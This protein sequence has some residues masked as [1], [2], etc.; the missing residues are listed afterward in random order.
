MSSVSTSALT[1]GLL[2]SS[3]NS[4]VSTSI[5]T[6]GIAADPSPTVP[7]LNPIEE[8]PDPADVNMI[9]MGM[10]DV[11]AT[12]AAAPIVRV[13]PP[14]PIVR[15]SPPA[16]AV[17]DP[18][19]LT[20][21]L[22]PI[23]F[24]STPSSLTRTQLPGDITLFT[25]SDIRLMIEVADPL[26]PTRWAKQLIEASTLTISV[27]RVK[28]P[29][30]A[31]GYIGAKGYSRGGRT[32]AGTMVLTE[33]GKDALFEFLAAF[34][35]RD[36]SKDSNIV[37]VDQIP[38][39]NITMLLTNEAGFASTRRLLGVDMITD[40][41]V[42]SENDAYTERTI[43]YV[44]ADFTPLL[45][46]TIQSLQNVPSASSTGSTLRETSP[47]DLMQPPVPS[48]LIPLVSYT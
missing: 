13:A 44:A 9:D 17:T 24:N 7:I 15:Q 10:T 4:A 8:G 18:T 35:L 46:T 2:S 12:Q 39:F 34:A 45:P 28:D 32:I 31:C 16:T 19:T 5:L 36:K 21:A 40:G 30:R 22:T 38:P 37:K 14:A 48:T 6:G 1:S 20:S 27:H 3:P 47:I 42:Y 43:S 29:A 23:T 33:L 26:G 11:A 25:G 41:T